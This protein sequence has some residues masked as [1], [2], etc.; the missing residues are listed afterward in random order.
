MSQNPHSRGLATRRA[1]APALSRRTKR[2][3]FPMNVSLT[4]AAGTGTSW[5]P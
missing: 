5:S 1:G 2:D 4:A 3:R